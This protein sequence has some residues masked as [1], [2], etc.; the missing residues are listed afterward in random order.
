MRSGIHKLMRAFIFGAGASLHV[1]YPLAKKLGR[2]LVDWAAKNPLPEH[3]YWTDPD[4]LSTI[5]SQQELDD[6]EWV[7]TELENPTRGSR[8]SMLPSGQRSS[9][10]AGFRNALCYFFDSIRTDE[11]QLYRQF[12]KEVIQPGDMVITFNYDV[13]LER[14]LRRAGKWEIRDGYGFDLGVDSLPPS[15]IRVLKLHGSTNWID[16]LFDGAKGGTFGYFTDSLGPR[17]VILPQEFEFLEYSGITDPMFKGGGWDRSGSI[18]LP[19]RRK[20][21]YVP[22]SVNSRERAPF[23]HALWENARGALQKA[24]KIVVVGCSLSAADE[25]AQDLVFKKINHNPLLTVCCGCDNSRLEQAFLS[26][27]FA[28]VRTDLEYFVDYIAVETENLRGGR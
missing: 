18:I 15:A 20:R 4:E 6:F 25:R 19:G 16:L 22:T 13:S 8:A 26:A 17:P 14:E 28:H 5:F 9:M 1:G 27:G 10:L 12:A 11:A 3:L 21:F 2:K 24:D 7:I 23:W